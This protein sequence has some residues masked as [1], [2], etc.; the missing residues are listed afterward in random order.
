MKKILFIIFIM[1]F[2]WP[3]FSLEFTV[4]YQES[5]T[6]E[7]NFWE[8]YSDLE[9]HTQK[10]SEYFK[11]SEFKIITKE[12][13][14]KIWE[15]IK[16]KSPFGFIAVHN[17]T[18]IFRAYEVME[19]IA[20]IQET[21]KQIS[22][23]TTPKWLLGKWSGSAGFEHVKEEIKV[24]F[25]FD[26]EKLKFEVKYEN[27]EHPILLIADSISGEYA[28]YKELHFSDLSKIRDFGTEVVEL[29]NI[30][31]NK[32]IQVQYPS[33]PNGK[34]GLGQIVKEKMAKKGK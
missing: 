8:A 14:K 1:L 5:D 4:F 10:A 27:F 30:H 32:G 26:P 33:G 21:G 15:R 23:L 3:S 34:L 25:N 29:L 19:D 18:E 31:K 9:Y 28:R 2:Y 6:S 16:P 17:S 22:K 11:N 7:E 12:K 24:E 20:I 13:D